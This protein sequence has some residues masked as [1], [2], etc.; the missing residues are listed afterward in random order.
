MLFHMPVFELDNFQRVKLNLP[1]THMDNLQSKQEKYVLYRIYFHDKN[2]QQNVLYIL[3]QNKQ[4]TMYTSSSKNMYSS[5]RILPF[6][7]FTKFRRTF[8]SYF[9]MDGLLHSMKKEYFQAPFLVLQIV[10]NRGL[11]SVPGRTKWYL[12]GLVDPN[13]PV[14]VIFINCWCCFYHKLKILI[15]QNI[16]L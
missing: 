4:Y 14:L 7:P 1:Q 11:Y 9:C 10:T 12:E 5:S 15:E 8:H 16:L 3:W 2:I 13:K 6:I